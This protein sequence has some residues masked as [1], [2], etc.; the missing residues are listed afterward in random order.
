MR[1]K[2]LFIQEL[3][4]KI[5]EYDQNY[6]CLKKK[7]KGLGAPGPRVHNKAWYE[8][9]Y[10]NFLI[11]RVTLPTKLGSGCD[12][13]VARSSTDPQTFSKLEQ[14]ETLLL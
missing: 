8:R 6:F 4:S 3:I 9:S 13:Y 5:S 11:K 12:V 1:E 14:K 7:K 2:N 10:E